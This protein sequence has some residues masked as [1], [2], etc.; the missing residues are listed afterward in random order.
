MV[1]IGTDDGLVKV[2]TNDGKAWTD[3]TPPEMTAW[4]RVTTVEASHFDFN[5]A[6]ASVDRHQ[7]E[8]FRPYVYR[9]RDM[10][11]TWQGITEGLPADGYVHVVREDPERQGLLFAGT[12]R[13]AFVSFDDGDHWQPL[14]LNLPVTSVRDFQIYANDLIVATHG[15]GFW[16]ID[17]IG[18]LRQADASVA[19][20]D[21]YL[22]R[23]TDTTLYDQGG[24]NG[25]PFQKDE[26][27][28]ENPPEGVY[29]DYWLGADAP[30]AVTLEI[31][32]GA[33]AVLQD[34]SAPPGRGGGPGAQG[35]GIPRTSPLWQQPPEPFATSAGMHR[36][37]WQP[38]TGRRRGFGGF[39]G[40]G[41]QLP[42]V[43]LPGEFTA[44]LTVNGN[45]QER[46][47][48]VLPDPRAPGM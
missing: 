18:A 24:D 41:P 36:A 4:S 13:G 11:R 29:I 14:Q 46:K 6:Y 32:D 21:A 15:R 25:T 2:T 17:D 42:V 30:G 3:V 31:L 8:D 44:R 38:N 27:Q 43:T 9:T 19:Q 12:E 22:Y 7:L 10:G 34:L 5:A 23:P 26:P 39:G 20:A 48:T 45:R 40:R 37:V 33:G 16:A 35:G 28:A 47:F 1:W